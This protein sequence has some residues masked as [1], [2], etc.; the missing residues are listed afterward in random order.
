MAP[1]ANGSNNGCSAQASSPRTLKSGV[2]VPTVAFFTPQD[3]IDE[4]TTKQHAVRVARAGVAGLVTHGSNGEAVH[5]DHAE[6]AQITKLTRTALDEG[7]FPDLPLIVGCGAQST[8]ETIQLCTEA[9]QAGGSHVLVLPPAYYGSLLSEELVAEHFRAVADA[10]PLPVL[11]YN[12][13][14]ACSGL[15]LSSDTILELAQHPNICGVK[16]TCGN[17]GKLARVVGGT[18]GNTG[19]RTFGGS[20][21]FLVQ[22]LAVGGH[23]VIAG[24]ANVVPKACV[25]LQRL[26]TVGKHE[27]ARELQYVV[28]RGDWVAIKGGFPSV[29]V[30]L[31]KYYGYGGEARRP[32]ALLEGPKLKAQEDAFAEL[33]KEEQRL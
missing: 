15:D 5:L 10:S 21:D 12:F 17:T 32:I 18:R 7:G 6:R 16:L 19:F 1:S 11:I 23:G 33:V 9:A 4:P 26:Y 2:Y 3:T 25:E 20:A 29:K 14:G 31:R 28:A 8:R 13:P 27:Q 22:T 24:L 30:A